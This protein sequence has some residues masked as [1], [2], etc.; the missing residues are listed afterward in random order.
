MRLL[1]LDT[2]TSVCAVAL[3][4]DG[5]AVVEYSPVLH[6]THSQ[7]LVPLLDQALAEAGWSRSHLDAIAVGA[8]PGSFTG[9]RIGMTTAKAL[10]FALD[11]PL[12]TVS[13][14]EAS[15]LS[16][17][18]GEAGSGPAADDLVCPLLDAR[19]GEVYTALYRVA[20]PAQLQWEAEAVSLPVEEWL[21]RLPRGET[22]WFTGE[23]VPAHQARLQEVGGWRMV[24]QPLLRALAVGLL[25]HRDAVAGRTVDPL[26]AVPRYVRRP[27]PEVLWEE[28]NRGL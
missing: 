26:Q 21:E 24:G 6:R 23:G 18:L 11:R 4:E 7:R 17:L 2:A 8:G 14:L 27:Q 20:G 22:A 10:A 13:T 1:A 25:G 15:A 28:R 5:R 9:V 19:R 3:M 16:P 12:A